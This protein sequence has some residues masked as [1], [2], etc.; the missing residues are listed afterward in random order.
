MA[1]ERPEEQRPLEQNNAREDEAG[2]ALEKMSAAAREGSAFTSSDKSSK[3]PDCCEQ[4]LGLRSTGELQAYVDGLQKDG[5]GV[6]TEV[7]KRGKEAGL[8]EAQQAQLAKTVTENMTRDQNINELNRIFGKFQSTTGAK[9]ETNLGTLDQKGAE[10]LM[11]TLRKAVED[12][13]KKAE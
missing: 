13:G 6:L 10:N 1:A 3:L 2:Q 4:A 12:L 8:D 7:A 11:A 9:F 5:K